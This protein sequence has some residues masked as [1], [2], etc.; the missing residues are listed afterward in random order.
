MSREQ[1]IIG[2]TLYVNLARIPFVIPEVEMARM[3][4]EVVDWA[5]VFLDT[6]PV[7]AVW[8]ALYCERQ[9]IKLPSLKFILTSYEFTS[10]VHR[11]ILKR[12]FGVPVLNLYGSTETG[13]LLMENDRGEMKPSYDTA[14][15]EVND[16][17]LRQIG[18][19]IVTTLSNDF[20]P[21]LRYRIGDLAERITQP[22]GECYIIHGRIRDALTDGDGSRVTTWHVDQC[23]AEAAGIAH[24][25]LRQ[26]EDDVFTLRFIPDV[27]GPTA[28]T[29]GAVTARLENLLQARAPIK[30]EAM[31][32]LVPAASGK[33]RLTCRLPAAG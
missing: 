6:D 32:T 28:E 15:L 4:Q 9:G 31:T 29:L 1:R 25:E 11:R 16:T 33:F 22:H 12:V 7:H 2:R 19:L 23:F 18:D 21:L 26:D 8:F 20:M 14:F 10:F 17:D 13:H 5:P 3:A 24:Y 27:A 30:T